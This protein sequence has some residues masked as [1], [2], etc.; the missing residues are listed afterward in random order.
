ME[1]SAM[2]IFIENRK[3]KK[4]REDLDKV[5]IKLNKERDWYVTKLCN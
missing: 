4:E 5:M 1:K 3:K 2:E